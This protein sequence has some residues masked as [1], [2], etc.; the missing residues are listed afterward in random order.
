M[1]S[2]SI[3]WDTVLVTKDPKKKEVSV[4]FK[5]LD[6]FKPE[7]ISPRSL[8][9]KLASTETFVHITGSAH[10]V[11]AKLDSVPD[12]YVKVRLDFDSG[13]GIGEPTTPQ[14]VEW[15]PGDDQL[16]QV[17]LSAGVADD[18]LNSS[19]YRAT[20]TIE[21]SSCAVAQATVNF[22]KNVIPPD[23]DPDPIPDEEDDGDPI[24]G[25]NPE[26]EPHDCDALTEDAFIEANRRIAIFVNTPPV[27]ASNSFLNF[28]GD[29]VSHFSANTSFVDWFKWG[30]M[31][32]E[33]P[34][35]FDNINH[36]TGVNSIIRDGTPEQP[37]TDSSRILTQ[38]FFAGFGP[39]NTRSNIGTTKIG[40]TVKFWYYPYVGD[41]DTLTN[42]VFNLSLY[43]GGYRI[44]ADGGLHQ[45]FTPG[46]VFL[47]AANGVMGLTNG[48]KIDYD[49]TKW[50]LP[51][52]YRWES[53]L[54]IETEENSGQYPGFPFGPV[55]KMSSS[56][57]E[58]LFYNGK[59]IYAPGAGT[60]IGVY[61]ATA[62]F[63]NPDG[64]DDFAAFVSVPTNTVLLG[65]VRDPTG[66][67]SL[68]RHFRGYTPPTYCERIPS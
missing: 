12:R 10:W 20:A 7:V 29:P 27:N 57:S 65:Y 18:L 19:S 64:L 32:T 4:N 14:Y 44:Y 58:Q 31:L 56:A 60:Q 26:C 24:D 43:S 53:T 41:P 49:P 8:C 25:E 37:T 33:G 68:S 34:C 2:K 6:G 3:D 55:D 42:G 1:A 38:N 54:T 46:N 30:P 22:Q 66:E 15:L 47:D 13:N 21:G 45:T 52:I 17:A 67:D 61:V 36:P 9:V 59:Y 51:I 16:K 62:G 35:Q 23:P 5:A 28:E 48:S 63:E 50:W 11:W 40:G 39:E